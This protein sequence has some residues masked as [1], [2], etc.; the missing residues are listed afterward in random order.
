MAGR[1]EPVKGPEYFIEAARLVLDRFPQV[2]F[3]VIGDGSL[4]NKLEIK[5]KKLNISR[6]FIFTGWREDVPELLSILDI[7]ALPSLN[8][9]VGRILIEAGACGIPVVATEVGGVP[10]IVKDK[11]TGILVPAANPLALAQGLATLL[12]DKEK[13]FKMGAVARQWVDDKFST[14]AMVNKFSNLYEELFRG[15]QF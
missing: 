14:R 3:L 12:K 4:R 2:K 7:L 13:R 10:E 1:L 6:S 8:E 15:R 9:A 11:E 5:C